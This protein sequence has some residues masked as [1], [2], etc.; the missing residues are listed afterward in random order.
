MNRP[1]E[2]KYRLPASTKEVLKNSL[3]GRSLEKLLYRYR[4]ELMWR[5][6]PYGAYV[7]ADGS[8]TLFDR[9]YRPIARLARG[10]TVTRVP[11][12]ERIHFTGQIWLYRDGTHPL[13]NHATRRRCETVLRCWNI[14]PKALAVEM[15]AEVR[16]ERAPRRPIRKWRPA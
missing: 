9:R 11:P 14:D 3:T 16:E 5:A 4:A 15:L 2:V 7:S 8:A 13:I 1:N 6:L 10:G 12:D